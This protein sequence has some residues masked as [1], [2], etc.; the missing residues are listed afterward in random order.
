M[1]PRRAVAALLACGAMALTSVLGVPDVQAATVPA[2]ACADAGELASVGLP[3][4]AVALLEAAGADAVA[5]C[6][7]AWAHASQRVAEAALLAAHAQ[8]AQAEGSTGE[9]AR[10]A[11]AA[12]VLDRE[13]ATAAQVGTAAGGG[14][15][16][17]TWPERAADQLQTFTT[18]WLEPLGRLVTPLIGVL[19][20]LLLMARVVPLLIRDWPALPGASA[21]G[22]VLATGLL[23]AVWSSS[24][25]TVGMADAM[26]GPESA[27]VWAGL[28]VVAGSILLGGWLWQARI[29][30][31]PPV[32][33]PDG[34]LPWYDG[35]RLLTLGALLAL[36]IGLSVLA[37]LL[38]G[39]GLRMS[40][41]GIGLLGASAA[42]A[43]LGWWLATRLR[44]AVSV[45]T[46]AGEDAL[47]GGFI[48]SLL[49]DLGAAPPRG[50]EV[51]TGADASELSNA[52]A[53]IPG[54]GTLAAKLGAFLAGLLGATPWRA[55]VVMVPG[56]ALAVRLS[57]SGHSVSAVVIRPSDGRNATGQGEPTPPVDL[58]RLAAA[59]LLTTLSEH[60]GPFPGLAGATSWRSLG[61]HYIA[62]T[63]LAAES[64]REL[65]RQVVGRAVGLDPDNRLAK[66][67]WQHAQLRRSTRPD[68]LEAYQQWLGAFVQDE[69]NAGPGLLSVRLRAAYSRAAV[70]LNRSFVD[71]AGPDHYDE[72]R[73]E[74]DALVATA[75]GG[76]PWLDTLAR[77][78]ATARDCLPPTARSFGP[79]PE[80]TGPPPAYTAPPGTY[81][82]P[83]GLYNLAAWWGSHRVTDTLPGELR[84]AGGPAAVA[85]GEPPVGRCSHVP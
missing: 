78:I 75:L 63:D 32:A 43:L 12:L 80:R 57:R 65:E 48:S 84:P 60:H 51:P 8:T 36:A 85:A 49:G 34:S 33:G 82:T 24:L 31:R 44:V 42:V 46:D 30:A 28:V 50:L 61:L 29:T 69:D 72:A 71:P 15:P 23:A 64:S 5:Q 53:A 13:N 39:A 21:R 67:A 4:R 74:L 9:A 56:D 25:L 73:A 7:A 62:T 83:T 70:T 58:M 10:V 18:E 68:E 38:A 77:Q 17:R 45:R 81:E 76:G 11:A 52:L 79:P 6:S 47:A 66:L 41:L 27:W 35:V 3:Q 14:A 40:L 22:S 55:E 16:E 37:Q 1:R 2:G 26:A 20:A 19:A 54:A 59:Y